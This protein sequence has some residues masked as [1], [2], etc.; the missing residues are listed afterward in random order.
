MSRLLCAADVV[1]GKPGGLSV[2]EALACGRPF[3]ATCCL[4][5][6]ERHNVEFLRRYGMGD[7]IDLKRLSSVL[8]ELFAPGGDLANIKA[9]A[10]ELGKRDGAVKIAD[11]VLQLAQAGGVERA[12]Y[13]PAQDR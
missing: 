8:E 9:R 4:G 1:V 3:L 11:L 7:L 13:A 2:S 5:G 12:L 10:F 6:Q